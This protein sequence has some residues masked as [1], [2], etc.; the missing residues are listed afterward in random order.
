MVSS[1]AQGGVTLYPCRLC[2]KSSLRS[3][4]L[5]PRSFPVGVS[6]DDLAALGLEVKDA[7]STWVCSSCSSKKIT[8]T[9]LRKARQVR[10]VASTGHGPMK[11]KDAERSSEEASSGQQGEASNATST[12]GT[13]MC[14][15]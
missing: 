2:L 8:Q 1:A 10:L 3:D 5:T 11:R 13:P 15:L 12:A 9:M 7:S 14:M 6:A 4:S